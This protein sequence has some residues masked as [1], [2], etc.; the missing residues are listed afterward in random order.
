MRLISIKTKNK[1]QIMKTKIILILFLFATSLSA[2][3][4][5]DSKPSPKSE[6]DYSYLKFDVNEYVKS[7]DIIEMPIREIKKPKI[8]KFNVNDFISEKDTIEMPNK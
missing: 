8:A 7:Y 1:L 6:A 4:I 2:K 5:G 3:N